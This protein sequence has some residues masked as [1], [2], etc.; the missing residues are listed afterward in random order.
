[1]A[2]SEEDSLRPLGELAGAEGI[3]G[4]VVN[5]SVILDEILG[6]IPDNLSGMVVGMN[7]FAATIYASNGN[8]EAARK[9]LAAS[10]SKFQTISGGRNAAI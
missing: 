10:E 8:F 5:A 6:Q 3:G 9:A 1:M 7:S 4:N 2:R